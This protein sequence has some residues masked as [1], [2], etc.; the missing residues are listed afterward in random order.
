MASQTS[1]QKA[2]GSAEQALAKYREKRNFD[3]TS[4]PSGAEPV[5]AKG[6]GFFVVQKHAATRAAL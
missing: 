2:Q 5:K 4:E 1:A 6:D 3:V